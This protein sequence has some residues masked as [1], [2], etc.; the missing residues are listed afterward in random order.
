MRSLH[1]EVQ[2]YRAYNE[3]IMRALEEILQI[4]NVLHK[5]VK[6]DSSTKQAV[7]AREV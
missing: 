2:R 6:K 3:R 5:K 1:R 7:I 4:L